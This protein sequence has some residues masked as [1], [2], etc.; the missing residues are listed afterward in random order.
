M[1][2]EPRRHYR[3]IG[4]VHCLSLAS[5]WRFRAL[6]CV[7]GFNR[8]PLRRLFRA[9]GCVLRFALALALALRR[10]FRAVGS[11]LGRALPLP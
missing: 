6:G 2:R 11:V 4:S 7:L 8:R 5:C 10:L 3:A 1:L 9:E